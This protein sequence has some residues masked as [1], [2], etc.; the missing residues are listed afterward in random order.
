MKEYKLII[1]GLGTVGK[2]AL[3]IILKKKS[4]KLVAAF[5]VD[6]NKVGRDA[7]EIFGY[8]KLGVTVSNDEEAV[9]NTEADVVLYYPVTK[10]DAN[11]MPAP[12]AVGGNVDDIVKFLEAGKNCTST[13]PVY[14]SE[15]IAPEYFEKI[16]KAGKANGT[17]YVQQGIYPGLFTPYFASTSMMFT[18]T[19]DS[20]IVYGGE[21]DAVNSAPWIAVFGFGKKLEDISKERL[22]V[23]E[24][25]IYTYYGPTVIEMAER[26]GLAWDEYVCEHE[27]I[28]SDAEVTTPYAHVLPETVGAHI[29]TMSTKKDGKEVT[30]FHFIHKASDEILPNLS[31]D[32]YI[33]IKGEPNLKIT[34]ENIIPYDDP[35]LTS[36]APGIN[37]IPSI[38]EAEGGMKNALDIPMGYMPR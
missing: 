13:L 29:F 26:A 31:L 27:T 35:F 12:T 10:W 3:D 21:D 33:E 38:C 25:I 23:V 22:A 37:L 32:K 20:A 28:L 36:A 30:G 9:L 6:E 16:D 18:R 8:D 24:N 15:K 19:I 11:K 1:W 4:L 5:D 34:L 7:G 17:T 14:F 2:S